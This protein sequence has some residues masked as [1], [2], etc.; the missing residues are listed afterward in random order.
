MFRMPSVSLSL[1]SALTGRARTWVCFSCM[2]WVRNQVSAV[3][4]MANIIGIELLER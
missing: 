1:P 4:R 2:F 3:S